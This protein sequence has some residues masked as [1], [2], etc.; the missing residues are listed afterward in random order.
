MWKLTGLAAIG[1][2]L[3]LL[4]P[5]SASFAST[6]RVPLSGGGSSSP[7]LPTVPEIAPNSGPT[8][9]GGYIVNFTETGLLPGTSW[10]VTVYG[11]GS[12]FNVQFDAYG[13]VA[14]IA[15]SDGDYSW[16]LDLYSPGNYSGTQYGYFTVSGAD[17][18]IRIT[19]QLLE[20]LHFEVTGDPAGLTWE[21]IV[22]SADRY[23]SSSSLWVNV[24]NGTVT[25]YSI[26][27]PP[28]YESTP[29]H[30]TVDPNG[31]TVTVSLV[32]AWNS[33]APMFDLWFN[34]TGLPLGTPWGVTV[35]ATEVNSTTATALFS[36]PNGTYYPF[37]VSPPT[38]FAPNITQGLVS[39]TGAPYTVAINFSYQVGY[40]TLPI[41][42]NETGLP[43][44]A[45]WSVALAPAPG[46]GAAASV[47]STT[48]SISDSLPSGSHGDFVI[49]A[50]PKYVADPSSGTYEVPE[51]AANYS[52]SVTF[53][54]RPLSPIQLQRFNA[55]PS[56]IQLGQVVEI[57]VS[58]TGGFGWLTYSYSGLPSPCI[59]GNVSEL[60]CQPNGTGS[61]RIG[62]TVVDAIGDMA[63]GNLTLEVAANSS[64]Q[65]A[66]SSTGASVPYVL[67][68]TAAAGV[69]VVAAVAVWRW[70]KR[71]KG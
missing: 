41:W 65:S 68:G 34:E 14:S 8:D 12:A 2:T 66:P 10:G 15:L 3:V 6:V 22:G 18:A 19:V 25:D 48:G 38:A 57:T 37:T 27:P 63:A 35:D 44:G 30:G 54:L 11:N 51:F 36:V 7:G 23:T 13:G 52:V 20:S 24:P 61:Y 71:P 46:G 21:A 17:L 1:L 32:F 47:S 43:D 53:A 55:S 62:L 29:G 58:T 64:G 31:S 50:S 45:T 16:E 33:T 28:G 4:A 67:L 49:H 39:I 56:E 42:F 9:L 60:L 59:G 70:R 26:A 69:A 5:S 40:L